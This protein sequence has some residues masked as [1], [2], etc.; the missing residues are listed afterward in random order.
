[1]GWREVSVK[2]LFCLHIYMEECVYI[3]WLCFSNRL[4]MLRRWCYQ[5]NANNIQY[6]IQAFKE[7]SMRKHTSHTHP[8]H[9]YPKMVIVVRSIRNIYN[10][11]SISCRVVLVVGEEGAS[12]CSGCVC[13]GRRRGA[14]SLLSCWWFDDMSWC[15]DVGGGSVLELT[16]QYGMESEWVS[17]CVRAVF[18][19]ASVCVCVHVV[20]LSVEQ[21]SIYAC[22]VLGLRIPYEWTTIHKKHFMR[23][24]MHIYKTYI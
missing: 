21:Y 15:D 11:Y 9:T 3:L 23:C 12:G 4:S 24:I 10:L 1:M 18:R 19:V 2:Y 5:K 20:G 13:V 22:C 16:P 14:A 6:N 8:S 17:A 7:C